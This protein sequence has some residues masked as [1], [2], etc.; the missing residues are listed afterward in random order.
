VHSVGASI[1]RRLGRMP[2]LP[3]CRA[4]AVL[5]LLACQSYEVSDSVGMLSARPFWVL[6]SFFMAALFALLGFSVTQSRARSVGRPALGVF[7]SARLRRTLPAYVFIILVTAFVIGLATTSS[8]PQRYMSDPDLWFYLLNLV[9]VPQFSLPGVFE[10]NSLPSVVNAIV[11]V[12]PVY[13]VLLLTAVIVD[14]ARRVTLLLPWA[15]VFLIFATSLGL[16]LTDHQPTTL[17]DFSTYLLGGQAPGALLAGLLGILTFQYRNRVPRG[18]RLALGATLLLAVIAFG[19]N[20]G[21]L[22]K[23]LFYCLSALPVAYVAIYL[24]LRPLPYQGLSD[25]LR[26]WLTG[27]FLYSFPI[28]QLIIAIGPREQDGLTNL[29]F[30][31]PLALALAVLSSLLLEK[32]FLLPHQKTQVAALAA[33]TRQD[34][35]KLRRSLPSQFRRSIPSIIGLGLFL[36]FI[37]GV[38]G[39]LYLAMLQDSGGI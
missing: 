21:W 30:S 7:I 37:I 8:S 33:H 13:L 17:L 11:W 22:G 31:L 1:E 4:I 18:R 24:C 27:L 25:R 36:L 9:A 35:R 12:M 28:Q 3:Q 34:V 19:G 16:Q 39:M 38:M 14:P 6:P 32:R 10:V 29:L 15:L 5:G 26:P 20:V 23:P 2:G